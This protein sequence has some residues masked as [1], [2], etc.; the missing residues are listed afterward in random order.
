MAKLIL[1]PVTRIEGHLR[2]D[3]HVEN[4][5]VLEAWSRGEMFRGLESL[6][7][8]R[9]PLDAPAITQRIC[10]V[11]P[12]SHGIAASR[13]LEAAFGIAP[14]GNGRLLRNLILGANYLQNHILHFYQLSALDF[15]RVETLLDYRG[16]D[17][18]LLDL[19]SWARGEMNSGR[20]LP[21]APL[22][23]QLPGRYSGTTEWNHL[24]L[25]HYLEAL[26]IRREAH[27]M[28]ALFGGKMPHPAS[29]V[30][31]GVTCG[32]ELEAVE[33][34]RSG[35]RR[36]RRFVEE[37]YLPDVARMVREFPEYSRQ[38]AGVGRFMSFGAFEQGEGTWL[39]AGV[40]QDGKLSALDLGAIREEVGSSYYQPGSGGA[41]Q[42][43]TVE[44]APE[45]QGAYSWIK[46]PRYNGE[47]MEVGPLARLLV[48]RAAGNDQVSEALTLMEHQTGLKPNMWD[49]VLGR[50]L[51]R[52]IEATLL[53]KEME[54]WLA[55][56]AYESPSVVHYQAPRSGSG[57]GLIEAPRG[58]LGHWLE[59]E[60]AKIVRYQCIV[61]STWNFSPRDDR[62][63]VGP[64]E[65]ALLGTTVN[66]GS[67][68][69]EV[70]RVVR[71]FD[72]CIA[73]AVH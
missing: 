3:T 58:G 66:E 61:P 55:Q 33:T 72:P 5:Q 1:D 69:L 73:C 63:G 22:L 64:V 17:R 15:I 19:Q 8:G 60:D 25:E 23:P 21:M 43:G 45:K 70:A 13:A 11:C 49:S 2:I 10:G 62:G 14:P 37:A 9:N 68:G 52:A 26:E 27:R 46:A 65:A 16:K 12:V 31:G 35:L 36:V 32:V 53:V 28:A 34:F 59:V 4:G 7:V 67:R 39:P 71:A 57:I 41:P 29:L 38:G 54:H 51:A 42:Q 47:A 24:A 30:P 18:E 44:L 48:A 50:H 6:L 56:L 20:I 40:L